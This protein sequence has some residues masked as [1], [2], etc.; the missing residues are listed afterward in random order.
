MAKMQRARAPKG[1]SRDRLAAEAL[2]L[3][4][5][6]GVAAFSIRGLAST[7]GLD[8]M[9]VLHHLGSRDAA[10]RLA[11]DQLLLRLA[12]PPVSGDWRADLRAV[13]QAFRAL[14][15]RHPNAFPLLLRHTSTGP[16]DYAQGERV[17]AALLAA[18]LDLEDAADLGLAFYAL[19]IGLAAAETG[20][21]LQPATAEET[22]ELTALK[23]ASHPATRML[24]PSFLTLNPQR[25]ATSGIN[26]FLDGIAA[27][28]AGRA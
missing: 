2:D 12:L 20:G 26:A 17:Y 21:M 24:I 11:G 19:A 3:I 27:R 1:F 7:V 15:H 23:A 16:A 13:A 4:E 9:T 22:A 8:P 6:R 14:A 25:A 18:G 10:V 28:V 5:R